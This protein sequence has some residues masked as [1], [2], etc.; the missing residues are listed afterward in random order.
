MAD[1]PKNIWIYWHQG[2]DAAPD[3][4]KRCIASWRDR[5]PEW[6]VHVLDAG[7]VSEMS[8]LDKALVTGRKDI[9]LQFLSDLIRVALLTR[10]GGVWADAT[11]YCARPLDKWLPERMHSGFF[12]FHGIRRGRL[13]GSPFMAAAKANIIPAMLQSKLLELFEDRYFSGNTV[14]WG[15]RLRSI[16]KPVLE[17]SPSTTRLWFTR[18]FTDWL[19][20]YPYFTLHY[21]FNKLAL[22]QENFADAWDKTPSMDPRL[23]VRIKRERR[24]GKV[25]SELREFIRSGQC[26][27]HKLNWQ[28]DADAKYWEEVFK[29]LETS[30]N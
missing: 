30:Q 15:K 13:L 16:L 5:N 11:I 3:I 17:L 21:M 25:S 18:F 12:A 22:E 26:P 27:V 20:L 10:H 6:T 28:S 14:W 1:I 9:S 8:G 23:L 19:K 24:L 4:V 2:E 29:E 7:N